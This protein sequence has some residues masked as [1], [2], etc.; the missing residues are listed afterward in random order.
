MRLLRDKNVLGVGLSKIG[1]TS[2]AAALNDLGINTI[3]NPNDHRIYH[4]LR[5]GDIG[6]NIIGR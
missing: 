4:Y 2:L 1:P 6:L 5:I 3:H